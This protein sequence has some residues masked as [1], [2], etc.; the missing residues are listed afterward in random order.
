MLCEI[1]RN[2]L[3]HKDKDSKLLWSEYI[4]KVFVVVGAIPQQIKHK[5]VAEVEHNYK[6]N[7]VEMCT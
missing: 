6:E 3:L 2:K 4:S 1:L 5:N 7:L